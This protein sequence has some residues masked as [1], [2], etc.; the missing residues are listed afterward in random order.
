MFC[1]VR[2]G[3]ILTFCIHSEKVSEQSQKGKHDDEE[4]F[5]AGTSWFRLVNETRLERTDYGGHSAQTERKRL[6]E[7]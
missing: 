4:T 3:H 5:V 1:G 6:V 7:R 2:W